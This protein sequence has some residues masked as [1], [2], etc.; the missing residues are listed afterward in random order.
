MNHTDFLKEKV[1]QLPEYPG[2]YKMLDSHRNIIY[3]GKS[4]CLKK[5]VQSYFTA[6]P[7]WEK[8]TRM[9]SAIRD[10]D[11]IVT[12]THLEAR[13]LECQLIKELQPRFNAQMKNDGR[14][15]YL[16]VENS[17]PSHPIS[18]VAEREEDCFGPFR[19]RYTISQFLDRLR[20][21]YPITWDADRYEFDYHLFPISMDS[22]VCEDNRQIL[23]ELFSSEQRLQLLSRSITG[24]MEEAVS[25]LQ[26]ELAAIYRDMIH[27]LKLIKNGLNGYQRLASR[28][29][30]LKLRTEDGFKLFYVTKG[31]IIDSLKLPVLSEEAVRRFIGDC[32]SLSDKWITEERNEKT[33]IDFRDVL[34]SEISDLAEDQYELL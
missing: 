33:F 26:F 2:I 20:C 21:L 1:K 23:L 9:V 34:Y 25:S 17:N 24:K 27:C 19:S 28:P 13:L 22:E 8:V 14:Y 31:R 15:F 12:D 7:K 30:L 18:V 3:V 16:K 11:Y 32:E 4:K 29:I 10:I 5:R 6:S